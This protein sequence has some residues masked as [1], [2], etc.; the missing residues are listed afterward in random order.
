MATELQIVFFAFL[1]HAVCRNAK[2]PLVGDID[3]CE[4]FAGVGSVTSALKA[5]TMKLSDLHS[6]CRYTLVF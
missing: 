6:F 2:A 1:G 3:A 4:I 5:D